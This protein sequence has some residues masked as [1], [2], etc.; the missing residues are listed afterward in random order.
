M[1]NYNEFLS[2]IENL[3][4]LPE[5]PQRKAGILIMND[6]LN[7]L[8]NS[9]R[10]KRVNFQS[11]FFEDDDLLESFFTT[12]D[13]EECENRIRDLRKKLDEIK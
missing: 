8:E 3:S 5:T 4:S 7:T 2:E 12:T 1:K 9:L 10:A 6:A 11:D 13:L